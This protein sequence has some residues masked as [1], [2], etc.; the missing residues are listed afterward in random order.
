MKTDS[1]QVEM[2]SNVSKNGKVAIRSDDYHNYYGIIIT[3]Y[4]YW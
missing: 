3:P 2:F 1:K 4:D